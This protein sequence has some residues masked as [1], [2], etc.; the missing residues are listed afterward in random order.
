MRLYEADF[1]AAVRPKAFF[2][3]AAVK[4]RAKKKG[5]RKEEVHNFM[6]H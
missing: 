3:N 1:E 2:G 6:E 5:G 4:K